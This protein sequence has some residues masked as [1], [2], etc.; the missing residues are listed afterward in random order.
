MFA[1]GNMYDFT[2]KL[3][4]QYGNR[5]SGENVQ[6]E[7]QDISKNISFNI[8]DVGKFPNIESNSHDNIL[9]PA[10]FLKTGNDIK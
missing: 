3:R 7:F 8:E 10:T 6:I 9:T 1:G 4:D 5:V 2:L